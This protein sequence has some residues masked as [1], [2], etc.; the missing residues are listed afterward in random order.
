MPTNTLRDTDCKGA[1]PKDK[2]YKLF[3]GGG[4]FLWVAPSGAKTWRQAYRLHGKQQTASH[5]EY[6]LVSLADARIKR[7]TLKKTLLSGESPKR[8]PKASITLQA[9]SDEYWGG[10]K[11]LSP[12]YKALATRGIELH[13][14]R[15][16]S[17]M[18]NTITRNDLLA[19][20]NA[21]DAK[22]KHNYVRKVRVWCGMV[23]D[24]AVEQGYAQINPA[25]LI[26]PK[27]AFKIGKKVSHAALPI[28]EIPGFWQQLRLEGE[29]LS[30]L[31]TKLLAYTWVR[32]KELRFMEWSELDG[33][34]WRIPGE[35]MKKGRDLLVPLSKQAQEI[36]AKMKARS[37]GSKYVFPAEHRLDR[38]MSEN[39]VL[40]LLY[41]LGLKGEMTGHG[42]RS[43]GSTWANEAGFNPDAIERQLAH[44][45]DDEVRAIYNRAKYLDERKAMLQAW[46]DW[47]DNTRL[48]KQGDM[49][50]L[51]LAA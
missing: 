44:V 31:A 9:A 27:K 29:I 47:L 23:F 32:T 28:T 12:S 34:L 17:R 40:A 50:A 6:P 30:V 10:R 37:R 20:L 51:H 26:D 49:P 13:L 15:L 35:R 36:I 14:Q 18:M 38:T 19:E 21:L 1:K 4:L 46:A 7:D 11:D 8:K 33:D 16:L 41:R 25:R 2:P 22:G 3:D 43:V 42:F 24:W 48:P 39:T 5:G 45:P